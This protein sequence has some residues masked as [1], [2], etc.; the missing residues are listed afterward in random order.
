MKELPEDSD[1][2]GDEERAIFKRVAPMIEAAGY[3]YGEMV[4]IEHE[5]INFHYIKKLGNSS[6]LPLHFYWY[7]DQDAGPLYLVGKMSIGGQV[8]PKERF[9]AAL[10]HFEIFD[11]MERELN[12]LDDFGKML[13]AAWDNFNMLN[14]HRLM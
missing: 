13:I 14:E 1:L 4:N 8:N 10:F 5:G 11:I 7:F 9:R 6:V 12:Q 3:V 2:F